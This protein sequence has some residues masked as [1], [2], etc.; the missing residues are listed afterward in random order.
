MVL[1]LGGIR[2]VVVQH[3][4]VLRDQRQTVGVHRAALLQ[5]LPNVIHRRQVAAL[6]YQP[7]PHIIGQT[8][9]NRQQQQPGRQQQRDKRREKNAAEY[10][11]SHVCSPI[12]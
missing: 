3:R 1:H 2:A 11:L 7:L 8:G 4:A 5:F 9:V 10:A 6:R 12:R